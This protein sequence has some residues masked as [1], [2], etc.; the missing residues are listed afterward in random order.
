VEIYSEFEKWLNNILANDISEKA[1]AFNFNIYDEEDESYGVQ[2]IA[3]DTF[4]EDDDDWACSEVFSSEEDIFYIDHSDEK[5]AD[6]KR[7]LEFVCGLVEQYLKD[8]QLSDK[9]KSVSAVGVG[10]IDGDI[11]IAFRK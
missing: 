1:V 4:T 8:G 5:N 2:L 6:H 7:G 3:S 11:T 10:F 9:L